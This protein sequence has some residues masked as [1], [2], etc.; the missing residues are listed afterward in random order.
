MVLQFI[1]DTKDEESVKAL[2]STLVENNLLCGANLWEANLQ[3]ANLQGADLSGANLRYANL[4]YANLRDA[5]LQGV[6]ITPSQL[7]QIVI[8]PE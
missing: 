2:I 8:A 7:T 4:R 3:G 6:W 1:V 5:N